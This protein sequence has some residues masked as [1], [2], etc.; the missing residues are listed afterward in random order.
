[1]RMCLNFRKTPLAPMTGLLAVGT[2]L[3]LSLYVG[4]GGV[5]YTKSDHHQQTELE[6]AL[7]YISPDG[8]WGVVHYTASGGATLFHLPQSRLIKRFPKRYIVPPKGTPWANDSRR[9]VLIVDYNTEKS[10]CAIYDIHSVNLVSAIPLWKRKQLPITA[11]LAPD[12]QYVALQVGDLRS[13]WIGL[14]VW[15]IRKRGRPQ[16]A[17][18]KS[19][20]SKFCWIGRHQLF[21]AEMHPA[22]QAFLIDAAQGTVRSIQIKLPHHF[23]IPLYSESQEE[24]P[25]IVRRGGKDALA[26]LDLP[27]GQVQQFMELPV[28]DQSKGYGWGWLPSSQPTLWRWFAKGECEIRLYKSPKRLLGKAW[29][30]QTRVLPSVDRLGGVWTFDANMWKQIGRLEIGD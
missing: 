3:F 16:L 10:H 26:V 7:P 21:A 11:S 2:L 24:V 22:H 8:Q 13:G 12:G 1:M 4:R 5:P 27:R 20:I 23:S 30:F 15:D 6:V 28:S 17:V 25:A 9:F 29:Q 19:G 14:Q 18:N